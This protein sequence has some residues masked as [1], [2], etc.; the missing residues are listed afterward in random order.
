M[1][2]FAVSRMFAYTG[3]EFLGHFFLT[4]KQ[5][6]FYKKWSRKALLMRV[7]SLTRSVLSW[8]WISLV[9][10]FN[11]CYCICRGGDYLYMGPWRSIY[12]TTTTTASLTPMIVLPT[13]AIH[14]VKTQY[15]ISRGKFVQ[16]YL[17]STHAHPCFALEDLSQC[18]VV[19]TKD[20][21][22]K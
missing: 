10:S 5:S 1:E 13:G 6:V 16:K 15:M 7:F 9:A 8:W 2:C 18:H 4:G 19:T 14:G 20:I 21:K 3:A 22:P 11:F 17:L 12:T